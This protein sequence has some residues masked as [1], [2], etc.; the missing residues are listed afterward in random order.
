MTKLG[1]DRG[2]GD[3][4]SQR[5]RARFKAF[6]R[7]TSHSVLRTTDQ[8]M[9]THSVAGRKRVVFAQWAQTVSPPWIA[10]MRATARLAQSALALNAHLP[11][12]SH[13]GPSRFMGP[14][15]N[16]RDLALAEVAMLR[17]TT[18]VGGG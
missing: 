14:R 7:Q 6:L 10:E 13:L 2:E 18:L 9:G 12:C 3:N 15:R 4:R 1:K 5:P 8:S 11:Q 17:A 16:L